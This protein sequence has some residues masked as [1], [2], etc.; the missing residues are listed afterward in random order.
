MQST[1][2]FSKREGKW[3]AFATQIYNYGRKDQLV[4]SWLLTEAD[5][6]YL[7]EQ[8]VPMPD[9]YSTRER[10]QDAL[11]LDAYFDMQHTTK[12]QADEMLAKAKIA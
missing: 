10:K 1:W 11:D 5:M 9:W 12:A 3:F 7:A 2:Q 8:G 6:S 4:H